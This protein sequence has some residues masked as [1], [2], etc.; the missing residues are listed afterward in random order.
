[1]QSFSGESTYP[2]T[3]HSH[4]MAGVLAQIRWPFSSKS[5]LCERRNFG[6]LDR[7]TQELQEAKKILGEVF[8]VSFEEVEEMIQR[9]LEERGR[10]EESSW[11]E[12]FCLESPLGDGLIR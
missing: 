3:H 9:R 7:R 2:C 11:P 6:K 1:M 10:A 5:E 8:G 12:R 4:T